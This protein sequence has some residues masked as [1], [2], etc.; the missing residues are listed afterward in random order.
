MLPFKYTFAPEEGVNVTVLAVDDDCFILITPVSPAV[1]LVVVFNVIVKLPVKAA[2]VAFE[3]NLGSKTV[4]PVV[5]NACWSITIL[6]AD[7]VIVP[8]V[9]SLSY[10]NVDSPLSGVAALPVAVTM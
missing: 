4:V 9:P 3:P 10:C 6:P 5:P 1:Q 8:R 2:T 7:N